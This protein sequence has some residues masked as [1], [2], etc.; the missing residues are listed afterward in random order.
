MLRVESPPAVF[1]RC[2]VRIKVDVR[3]RVTTCSVLEYRVRIEVDFR[4]RVTTCSVLEIQ[5]EN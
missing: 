3:G 2:R 1:L 4:G 5:G